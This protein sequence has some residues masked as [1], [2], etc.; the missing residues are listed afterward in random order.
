MVYVKKNIDDDDEDN[1]LR[2]FIF[3]MTPSIG[4]AGTP[5]GF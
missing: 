2:L 4:N 3:K 1:F 5:E